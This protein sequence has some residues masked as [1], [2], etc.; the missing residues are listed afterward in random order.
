[1]YILWILATEPPVPWSGE[2]LFVY[3]RGKKSAVEKEKTEVHKIAHQW[4]L[5]KP[6]RKSNSN[7]LASSPMNC[8][9]VPTSDLILTRK[10]PRSKMQT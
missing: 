2:T 10:I 6:C 4:R 1:M 5:D 7:I 9:L 8:P 3:Q